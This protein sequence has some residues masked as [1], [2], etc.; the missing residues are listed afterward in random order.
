MEY[1]EKFQS[2]HATARQEADV[3][4]QTDLKTLREESAASLEQ[5]RTAH[6]AELDSVRQ[7]NESVL[8][9]SIGDMIPVS[10]VQ[11]RG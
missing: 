10:I 5:L 6:Q 3:Q 2:L 7:G 9:S 4:H 8:A 11:D 1:D